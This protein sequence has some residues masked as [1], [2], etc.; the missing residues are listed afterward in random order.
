MVNF[1]NQAREAKIV[2]ILEKRNKGVKISLGP[3]NNIDIGYLL[4]EYLNGG[5]HKNAAGGF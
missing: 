3:K 4:K 2:A 5:G 1:L